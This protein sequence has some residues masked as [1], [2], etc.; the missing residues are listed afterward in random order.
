MSLSVLQSASGGESDPDP[1]SKTSEN[2][3]SLVNVFFHMQSLTKTGYRT[4]QALHLTHYG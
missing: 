2:I 4:G 3:N 1:A